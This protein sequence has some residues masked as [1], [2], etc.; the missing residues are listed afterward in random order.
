MAVKEKKKKGVLSGLL[1]KADKK[2]EEKENVDCGCGC[3]C[4]SEK[5]EKKRG[6]CG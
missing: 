3:C 1:D 2:A 6:C 4:T 5:D